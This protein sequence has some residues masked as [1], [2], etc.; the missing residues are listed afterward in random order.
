MSGS[1]AKLLKRYSAYA[2]Q[3]Y[4]AIKKEWVAM[5][6]KQR[7]ETRGKMLRFIEVFKNQLASSANKA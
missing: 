3:S 7:T 4:D 6:W 5:N 2:R 1:D